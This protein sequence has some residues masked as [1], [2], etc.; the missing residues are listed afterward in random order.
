MAAASGPLEE[1]QSAL[2]RTAG[3]IPVW[4]GSP[5]HYTYFHF[6]NKYLKEFLP[7]YQPR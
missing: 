2:S 3:R 5:R 6:L 7:V 1:V 4:E